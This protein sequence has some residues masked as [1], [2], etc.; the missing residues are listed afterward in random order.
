[1]PS[2][3]N[4]V[5][6]EEIATRNMLATPAIAIKFCSSDV[7]RVSQRL[8]LGGKKETHTHTKKKKEKEKR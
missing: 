6:V 7:W 3:Q 2:L 1:M 8:P 4:F 5:P